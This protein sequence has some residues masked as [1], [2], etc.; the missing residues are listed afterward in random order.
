MR[1]LLQGCCDSVW[2]SDRG[3]DSETIVMGLT[4]GEKL[5]LIDG[6]VYCRVGGDWGRRHLLFCDASNPVNFS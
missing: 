1:R 2:G 5:E 4:F 6:V 3:S